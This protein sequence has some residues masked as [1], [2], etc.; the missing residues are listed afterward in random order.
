MEKPPIEYRLCFSVA[1]T[2]TVF[3]SQNGSQRYHLFYY[4]PENKKQPPIQQL[5]VH[6]RFAF[7]FSIPYSAGK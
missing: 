7:V 6:I 5:S 4:Q 2:E 3:L 1:A